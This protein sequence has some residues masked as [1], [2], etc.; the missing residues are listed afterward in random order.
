MESKKCSRRFAL[1]AGGSEPIGT[2]TLHTL[3]YARFPKPVNAKISLF[4]FE[5]RKGLLK[6]FV[7]EGF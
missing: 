6:G 7:D 2:R 3:E 5:N 4:L 1:I